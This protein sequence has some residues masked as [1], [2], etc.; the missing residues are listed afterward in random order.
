LSKA[1]TLTACVTV[2]AVEETEQPTLP[3]PS[4]QEIDERIAKAVDEFQKAVFWRPGQLWG[5][6]TWAGVKALKGPWDIW[7]AQEIL[8]ETRPDLV[9]ETGVHEGGSTLFYAQM[10]DLIGHGEVLAVDIDLS[11]VDPRVPEHPRVTLIE[12]SSVDADV[13]ERIRGAAGDKRVMLNL[14]SDHAAAHVLSELRLLADVVTPGCYLIV[15]DTAIGRPLGKHLLPGPA[16]A[17][18]EWM[19]EGRPFEIDPTREKFL[20]TASPGGYLRRT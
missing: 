14:D 8:W 4:Q 17:L 20:L 11:T 1:L 15:E 2:N 19:A 9:V 16:E 10:L 6:N 5:N 7:I 12:G 3:Q 13:V 18:E